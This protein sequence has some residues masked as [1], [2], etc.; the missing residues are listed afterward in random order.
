M[1]HLVHIGFPKTGSNLVR[2]W[3]EQHPQL[4]YAPGG[5]GGFNDVYQ[6]VRSAAAGEIAARYFATSSE[7]FALPLEGTGQAPR[8]TGQAPAASAADRACTLL[9]DFFPDA[10]ILIVT[11][12]Y[13]GMILS[14]YSQYVRAGG[15]QHFDTLLGA[16]AVA[17]PWDYDAVVTG[18]RAAFGADRV[19]VLPY[20]LLRDDAAAFFGAIAARL[21]LDR[22]AL[23]A[24]VANPSLSPAALAWYPYFA[25]RVARLPLPRP[26]VARLAG[27]LRRWTFDDRLARIIAR[28]QRWRPRVPV[29]AA[30]IDRDQLRRQIAPP[31]RLRG[32]PA[33]Q[34]YLA[35]YLLEDAG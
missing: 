17:N 29:T 18:Y 32:E 7:S 26:L 28:L 10:H 4:H 2:Q 21:G 35:D 22:S 34:P 13:A 9:K 1:Q 31:E 30:R 20:E 16:V 6:M 3:F 15:D 24:D 27:L 12:G 23:P 5:L 25:G 8:A 11:R 33:Y 19:I 14:S